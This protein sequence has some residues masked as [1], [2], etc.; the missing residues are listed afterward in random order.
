[1]TIAVVSDTHGN[2]AA[3]RRAVSDIRSAHHIDL[4]IHLGDDYDDAQVFEEFSCDYVRVPGVFSD[5][6]VE[7]SVPNR[8]MKEFEGWRFLLSHTRQSHANDLPEDLKPEELIAA[9][10]VDVVLYGHTHTP[11]LAEEN[12]ILFVNPGHLKKEDKKGHAATYAIMDV[13]RNGITVKIV[14]LASGGV[15][16]EVTF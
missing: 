10:R 11:Q 9:K 14:E 12:G 8:V 13:E 2:L 16:E 1:M 7:G 6:Y 4:F 5:H 15:L 3:L